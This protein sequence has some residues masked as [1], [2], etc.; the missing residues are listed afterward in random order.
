MRPVAESMLRTCRQEEQAKSANR[1]AVGWIRLSNG[2]DRPV[3][4]DRSPGQRSGGIP[5]Q[6]RDRGQRLNFSKLYEPSRIPT[7]Q[8]VPWLQQQELALESHEEVLRALEQRWFDQ[9]S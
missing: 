5:R 8:L 2:A 9:V 1:N 7:G 6:P 3:R 4:S